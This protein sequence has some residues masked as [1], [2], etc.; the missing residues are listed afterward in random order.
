MTEEP[1]KNHWYEMYELECLKTKELQEQIEVKDI[2][3]KELEEQ[4]QFWKDSSFDWRHKF[5]KKGLVKRLVAKDKQLTQAKEF[6]KTLLS[7]KTDFDERR[8]ALWAW[9][10]EVN[11]AEQFLKDLEK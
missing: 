4:R 5:F 11:K 2:Q 1:K 3:I 8:F 6:I 7:S 9:K 10:E